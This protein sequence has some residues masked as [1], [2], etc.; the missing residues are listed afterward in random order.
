[1]EQIIC[2]LAFW[3]DVNKK[4]INIKLFKSYKNEIFD[5]RFRLGGSELVYNHM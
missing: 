4:K 5:R 3:P 2:Y 1:M